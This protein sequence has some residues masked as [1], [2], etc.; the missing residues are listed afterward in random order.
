[1]EYIAHREEDRVQLLLQHLLGTAE[2]ARDFA[3]KFG[4]GE[5]GYCC[6]MLHDIGKYSDK[7][8]RKIKEDNSISVDHATAG[9]RLCLEKQ[10]MY[11]LL[12]YCIAGHHAGLPDYGNELDT[13]SASTLAGRRKKRI[14]DYWL[15]YFFLFATVLLGPLRVL[16][17]VFVF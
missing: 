11:P 17:L 3:E 1:M 5:W 9:A 4:K 12:E 8:Q 16:A 7:F 2:R 6:G 10:G 15:N 13:G 14:E